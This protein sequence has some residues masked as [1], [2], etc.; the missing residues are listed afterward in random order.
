MTRR[1]YALLVGVIVLVG[2]IVGA[3]Q[4]PVQYAAMGPGVTFNTLGKDTDG[5]QIVELTGR[6]ANKTTGN[7]N[8]TTVSEADHLDLLSAIRGWLSSDE[9]VVPREVLFPPDKTT[10]QIDQQNAADF[11]QS[12]DSATSAALS[13]LKYPN[14]VVIGG[15]PE[16]SPAKGVLSVGDTIDSVNGQPIKDTDT[17]L[18]ILGKI[19]PGTKVTVGYTH[20]RKPAT[21]TIT[22]TKA[23]KGDGSALGVEV[24]FE[25][26]APFDVKISLA[27]IGGP[28]AGLMFALGIIQKAGPDV[29]LTGGKFIAGTGT[30]DPKGDVGPIGGIPLKMVG[31]KRA[32]ATI[33][34]VPAGNCAEAKA[35]HPSGLRM[36]KVSTLSGAVQALKSIQHGGSAPSC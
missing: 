8:M 21:G 32:G 24:V 36:I 15:L 4:L 22:T 14:K 34:L 2:L 23:Q 13:Y 30:I 35:D 9:S 6:N 17:L 3:S 5:K 31:A 33:F 25:P 19:K 12:Q 28:S 29:N 10:K 27:N 26:V 20:E 16:G 18:S 11:V 1:T 7:L